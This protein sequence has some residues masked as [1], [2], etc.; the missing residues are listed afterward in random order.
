MDLPKG[1]K[2]AVKRYAHL[3]ARTS[4]SGDTRSLASL[5]AAGAPGQRV[6][7]EAEE[8]HQAL[9]RAERDGGLRYIDVRPAVRLSASETTARG[10]RVDFQEEAELRYEKEKEQLAYSLVRQ[11]RT[12]W[13][14]RGEIW[15]LVDDRVDQEGRRLA[16]LR[17]VLGGEPDGADMAAA[18]QDSSARGDSTYHRDDAVAYADRWWNG[19]NPAYRAFDVDC[20]NFISQALTAG[21][22]PQW[23]TGRQDLG[24]WYRHLGGTQDRWSLSWSVAHSL[25]WY[26]AGSRQG[27][28]ATQRES[29]RQLVLGDV[30]HY[31]FDGDGVWE[32]S[33]IVVAKDPSGEPLVNAHTAPSRR[34]PWAYLDSPA[35]T[36]RT[37]YLFWQVLDRF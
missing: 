30:I 33:T 2:D 13:L 18:S 11:H 16:P 3:R 22:A 37:R 36:N 14:P 27:L 21:G 6:L 35:W 19:Y 8:E 1:I 34:R 4:Q 9:R 32:H 25:R 31:D 12:L 28:Q 20:T 7:R 10:V 17:P 23:D 15:V 29:A 5:L 26:L 24:W